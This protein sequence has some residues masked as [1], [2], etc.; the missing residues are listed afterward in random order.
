MNSRSTLNVRSDVT[1]AALTS[2][3]ASGE[4]SSVQKLDVLSIYDMICQ[5]RLSAANYLSKDIYTAEM[6]EANVRMVSY[7]SKDIYAGATIDSILRSE[8]YLSKE[9]FSDINAAGTLDTT[10]GADIYN[11]EVAQ[12]TITLK[13]GERLEIDSDLFT[14]YLDQKNVFEHYRGDWIRLD[15]RSVELRVDTGNNK[16]LSGSIMYRELFL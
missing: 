2:V 3:A 15:R 5:S 16:A 11:N 10:T 7:L 4:L 14:A 9:I 6:F 13:P 12:L 8:S 1:I